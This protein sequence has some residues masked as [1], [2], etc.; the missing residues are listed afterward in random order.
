MESEKRREAIAAYKE[1][2]IIPGIYAVRCVATGACWVGRAPDLSTIQNRLW[3]TLRLGSSPHRALQQAWRQNGA[4]SFSFE[5]V[6]ELDAE[7]LGFALDRVMG[8][9]H[10]HWCEQFAAQRI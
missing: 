2:T 5:R 4:E 8:E 10:D 1:R 7:E 3:F 9:R 6:E